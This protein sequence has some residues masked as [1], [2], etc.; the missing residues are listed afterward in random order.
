VVFT[1]WSKVGRPH[2]EVAVL[3]SRGDNNMT[4]ESGMINSQRAHILA[5]PGASATRW[6]NARS[7]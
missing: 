5:E 6:T 3:N 7:R 1:D 2:R 4:S